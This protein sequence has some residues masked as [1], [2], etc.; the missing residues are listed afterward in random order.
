MFLT[1]PLPFHQPDGRC[2]T[3]SHP[4]GSIL[5]QAPSF[6]LRKTLRGDDKRH[7]HRSHC[8]HRHCHSHSSHA[9]ND[10]QALTKRLEPTMNPT[11]FGK[12]RHVDS[13]KV[14]ERM[15]RIPKSDPLYR[16]FAAT[17]FLPPVPIFHWPPDFCRRF[18]IFTGRRIF[19][20]SSENFYEAKNHGLRKNCKK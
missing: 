19:A 1:V 14:G 5:T 18:R 8:G 13:P 2:Q 17:G 12:K 9:G 15:I 3:S 7:C 10:F 4:Y 6:E 16:I 20:A 11:K